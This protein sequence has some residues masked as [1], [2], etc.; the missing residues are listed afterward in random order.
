M[1]LG[2]VFPT[3]SPS[4]DIQ[5]SSNFGEALFELYDRDGAA[6]RRLIPLPRTQVFEVE[7]ER[8]KRAQSL[9]KAVRF[10][11]DETKAA[12]RDVFDKTGELIDPHSAIGVAAC[13]AAGRDSDVP[14]VMLATAHPA[15]F[16]AFRRGGDRRSSGSAAAARN[17]LHLPERYEVLPPDL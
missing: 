3:L 13:R 16:P 17:L 10:D 2:Q 5:V 14:T 6:V 7:P 1:E 4:M 12:I 11:D 8:L 15:K 9:F